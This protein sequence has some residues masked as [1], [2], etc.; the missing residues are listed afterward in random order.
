MTNN[1]LSSRYDVIV[2]GGGFAGVSAARELGV[3]GRNVVVVEARDRLGGRTWLKQNALHG[4]TLEMGGTWIDPR[5]PHV[6]AAAERY[7]LALG[8]P[9]YGAMPSTWRAQGKLRHSRLPV[10]VDELGALERLIAD[11]NHDSRRIS[12]DKPIGEQDVADLDISFAEYLAQR[13]LPPATRDVAAGFFQ[14]FGSAPAAQVSALHLIRRIAAAGSVGEFIISGA[15]HP[16]QEGTAALINSMMNEAGN[17]VALSTPVRA[18]R[19]T[20]EGVVVTTANGTYEAEVAVLAVP[21]NV[22]KSIDFQPALSAPKM[23]LSREELACAGTKVWAAVHGVSK[24][25]SGCG[26]GEGLDMLWSEGTELEDGSML[27]VAYGTDIAALDLSD[28]ADVERAIR[29]FVPEAKVTGIASH[30]WRRD[31]FALETWAVFRPG[32]IMKYDSDMRVPEGRIFFAGSHTAMRWPGFIDGA[33]ESGIRAAK[34]ATQR[35]GS[36]R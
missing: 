24:D 30:D 34:E 1:R 15:S 4:M 3:A 5:Q 13:R 26:L 32:Q 27:M 29:A 22:M 18:V 8:A 20:E 28:R 11:L 16:F 10:I 7:K 17:Q 35:L 23:A 33:I 6:W 2:I 9:V 31:P 36:N 25:F 12:F 19:Q 21:A 14:S